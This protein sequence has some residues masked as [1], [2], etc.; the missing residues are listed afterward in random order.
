MSEMAS[1]A[2]RDHG[3]LRLLTIDRGNSTL[4]CRLVGPEGQRRERLSGED[5]LDAFLAGEI[6]GRVAA[7]TVVPGALDRLRDRFTGQGVVFR[8]A[9]AELSCPLENSYPHPA[10]LGADRWVGAV[11]AWQR[12]GDAVIVDCGTAWTCNLVRAD[13]RFLGGAIGAGLTT[14]ALG[15]H[16]R[17]PGLPRFD[18]RAPASSP[19]VTTEDAVRIGVGHGFVRMVESVSVQLADAAGLT[20]AVRVLTGGEAGAFLELGGTGF[21]HVP[22]LIHEGLAWLDATHDSRC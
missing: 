3:G 10:S 18:G 13:G 8:T 9:G 22:D 6:P 4:D 12:F 15:L 17:A 19:A 1:G 2:G 7:V 21:V 11:A 20:D 14:M 16:A 5:A